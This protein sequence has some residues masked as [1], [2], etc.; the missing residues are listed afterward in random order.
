MMCNGMYNVKKTGKSV[1][2]N[3]EHRISDSILCSLW[4]LHTHCV[5][6]YGPKKSRLCVSMWLK[7]IMAWKLLMSLPT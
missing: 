1:L 5:S 2:H 4:S 7:I 3:A 6:I